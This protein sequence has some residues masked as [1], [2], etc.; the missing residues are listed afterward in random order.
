MILSKGTRSVVT[1]SKQRRGRKSK[2]WQGPFAYHEELELTVE[3]LTNLGWG[4]CRA[5][6]PS[7]PDAQSPEMPLPTPS[8]PGGPRES[9]E[10]WV[11]MVP[12]VIPGERIRLRIYRNH[13]NYSEADLM[14]VLESS[15]ER[16]EP[17]CPLFGTCGGCQ[18]QHMSVAAQ[19]AWKREHV[20]QVLARTGNV[21]GVAVQETIGTE[22]TLGYRSKITPHHEKPRGGEIR[23]IGFLKLGSR[24]L[25]DVPECAIAT[26]A[27]NARLRGLREEVRVTAR[28]AAVAETPR[29]PKGA[30]LLL[31]ETR[32]GVVTDPRAEVS[33]QV[34]GLL[35]K[36]TAGSFFQNNPYVLPHMVEYVVRK[37][38]APNVRYLVDA[39]CG[40]GL[41]CLSASKNF[42][43][44]YGV[45]ISELAILS[46]QRNAELNKIGNCHFQ[47]GDATDIFA[48]IGHISGADTVTILDPPRKGCDEGFLTQLCRF[49]PA[50]IVYVSCDPATQ[51]RDARFLLERGYD[52]EEVQPFDL[53]PQ[54]RHIENVIVFVEAHRTGAGAG[55]VPPWA[56]EGGTA[57]L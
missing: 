51:A 43:A 45:E 13:K 41:F 3:S 29:K 10:G 6:L 20:L 38:G 24:A 30:T 31:R 50:R 46:A 48:G 9:P 55:P 44:C 18:Y 11:V 12:G 16:V 19:R 34:G 23:E 42:E 14:H 27:I 2:P 57:S 7:V 33:D 35:F 54:T 1:G 4:I 56:G 53:F 26:P 39:Y 22:H 25:V 49:R 52:I 15:P 47:A 40:G 36:Y 28:A 37:A 21:T 32:E 5:S 8:T 17:A